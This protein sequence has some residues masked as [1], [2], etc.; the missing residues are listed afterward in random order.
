MVDQYMQGGGNAMFREPAKSDHQGVGGVTARQVSG[1]PGKRTLVDSPVDIATTSLR[2]GD[3]EQT[4]A[5]PPPMSGLG[6]LGLFGQPTTGATLISDR[7]PEPRSTEAP[8]PTTEGPAP[9]QAATQGAPS[10]P[11]TP[12][13]GPHT[14]GALT[15]AP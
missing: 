14:P 1:S 13:P 12:R 2:S 15:D 3:A 9:Q 6:P 5:T 11:E 8:Q 7:E 4:T 10:G